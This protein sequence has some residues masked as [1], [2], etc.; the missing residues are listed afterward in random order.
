MLEEVYFYLQDAV[1]SGGNLTTIP[2]E[3]SGLVEHSLE[4][5]SNLPVLVQLL[6]VLVVIPIY[7][8]A[9]RLMTDTTFRAD[10]L[11]IFKSR[12]LNLVPDIKLDQHEIFVYKIALHNYLRTL[13]LETPLKNKALAIILT[14]KIEVVLEKTTAFLADFVAE[15]HTGNL[16]NT[17]LLLVDNI[18]FRYEQGIKVQ[19]R[20]AF[21][22]SYE[23]LFKII[24]TETFAPQH[25]GNISYI[26]KGIKSL[27]N[28]TLTDNQKVHMFFNLLHIALDI[29]ILDCESTF[30]KLNGTLDKYNALWL[31]KTTK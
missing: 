6:L 27:D 8:I 30:R 19:F 24:Y 28:S 23:D 29:A 18:V 1:E 2:A 16:V 26:L 11:S 10:L 20:E 14:R 25:A 12:K 3:D 31:E 21:R 4:L 7:Y 13:N 17:M 15:K 22:D 9:Y 5:L